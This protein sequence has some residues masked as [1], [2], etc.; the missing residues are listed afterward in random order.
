MDLNEEMAFTQT[1]IDNLKKAIASGVLTVRHGDESV[2]YR[3]LA[4]LERALA[5]AENAVNG[6]DLTTR[7]TVAAFSKG[8]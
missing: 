5:R 7:R 3:S 8:L 2:T 6:A 1:D 4:D